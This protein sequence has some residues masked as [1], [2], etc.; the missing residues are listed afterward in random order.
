MSAT[1]PV[2][3]GM[4]AVLGGGAPGRRALAAA[5]LLAVCAGVAGP[6]VAFE[7][8]RGSQRAELR[9]AAC[10]VVASAFVAEPTTSAVR[11]YRDIHC[12]PDALLVAA[13]A[14]T[15]QGSPSQRASLDVLM[16]MNDGR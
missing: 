10:P 7:Q 15:R 4:F 14:A 13:M 9:A 1:L 11:T 6:V 5:S 8:V 12:D 3:H 16:A 2:T